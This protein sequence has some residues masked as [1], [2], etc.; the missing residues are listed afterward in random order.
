MPR[1]RLKSSRSNPPK[2]VGEILAELKKST[3]LGRQLKQAMIWA[4]WPEIA[5]HRLCSHGEP[6]TI[7]KNKL[8][9]EAESPVWMHRF[10]SQRWDIIKRVNRIAG[11][12]LISDVYVRLRPDS[13]GDSAQKSG[14]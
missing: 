11:R 3:R 4:C 13:D 14:R 8:Y 9:V 6:Y 12:E 1:A 10:V 5:G 7:E 2:R